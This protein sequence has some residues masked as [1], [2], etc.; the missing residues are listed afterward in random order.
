MFLG[1]IFSVKK[2]EKVATPK[3]CLILNKL[4]HNQNANK[5]KAA[6]VTQFLSY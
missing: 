5:G 4:L 3:I 2:R 1:V 6:V